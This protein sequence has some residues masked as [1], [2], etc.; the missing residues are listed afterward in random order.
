MQWALDQVTGVEDILK[1]A[2][3][4]ASMASIHNISKWDILP[5]RTSEVHQAKQEVVP[6]CHLSSKV[7]QDQWASIQARLTEV[8]AVPH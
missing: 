7:K 1:L 3:A 4:V 2:E 8:L 6:I 5:D